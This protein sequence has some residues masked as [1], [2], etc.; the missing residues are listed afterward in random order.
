MGAAGSISAAT[1]G[2][3]PVVG[4]DLDESMIN[5]PSEITIFPSATFAVELFA[6]GLKDPP[7]VITPGRSLKAYSLG[8]IWDPLI[9]LLGAGSGD[10]QLLELVPKPPLLKSDGTLWPINESWASGGRPGTLKLSGFDFDGIKEDNIMATL[11]LQMNGPGEA[12]LTPVGWFDELNFALDNGKFVNE[13]FIAYQGLT[14]NQVA[15]PKTFLLF[16]SALLGIVVFR[17]KL[18]RS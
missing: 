5:S 12:V 15:I 3:R 18:S 10:W 16:G 17:R 11:L 1:I 4:F 13:R 2:L 14:I 8:I 9:D 6:E 7:P